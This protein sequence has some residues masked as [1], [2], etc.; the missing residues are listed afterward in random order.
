MKRLPAFVKK[1]ALSIA[2]LSAFGISHAD[3]TISNENFAIGID[4]SSSF[5]NMLSVFD[6]IGG[7]LDTGG[8]HDFWFDG[9]G[10][11]SRT[12]LTIRR[13][14]GT[15]L[16]QRNNGIGWAV[17]P[18]VTHVSS[19]GMDSV[20][21]EGEPVAG[22]FMR[23]VI[24]IDGGT[25]YARITDTFTNNQG[26]VIQPGVLDNINPLSPSG[27]STRNDVQSV[28][29]ANDFASATIAPENTLTVGFGSDDMAYRFSAGGSQFL[30]NPF[31][32]AVI[33]PNGALGDGTLQAGS[34]FGLMLPAEEHSHT[35]FLAFGS[36]KAEATEN[37][38][39]ATGA[40]VFEIGPVGDQFVDEHALMSVAVPIN[41]P[42]GGPVTWTVDGPAG[43]TISSSGT[44][45]WTPG[46]LDGGNTYPVEVEATSGAS[47]ATTSFN[48]TVIETNTPPVIDPIADVSVDEGGTAMSQ[49]TASDS[50]IPVQS[51]TF[52][53]ATGPSGATVH[54]STGAFS[55]PTDEADGPGSY[56]VTVRVRDNGS[57]LLTDET[58]FTVFVEEVNQAPVLDAI[59]DKAVTIG[60]TLSFTATASDAD[61]PAN[62]LTFTLEPGAPEG[63]TIDPM[64][65]AFDWTPGPGTAGSH[66]VAVRV[67]DDGEPTMSDTDQ[68]LI[69]VEPASL[70]VTYD[71]DHS[72]EY[73]DPTTLSV[74]ITDSLNNPITGL[75]M[76]FT[77]GTFAGTDTT[78]SNG[79]ASVSLVLDQPAGSPG[80][81]IDFTGNGTFEPF[82]R[83][84]A[85]EILREKVMVTY[86]GDAAVVTGS[87]VVTRAA[88][89][90]YATAFQEADGYP[91]DFSG[92]AL[93]YGGFLPG[94]TGSVPDV[95]AGPAPIDGSGRS[96]FFMDFPAHAYEF[97]IEVAANDY[98]RV[99]PAVQ[100]NLNI[101]VG[102]PRETNGSG[103]VP[104]GGGNGHGNFNLRIAYILKRAGGRSSFDFTSEDGHRYMVE[105]TEL[106]QGALI[107]GAGSDGWKSAITGLARVVKTHSS[108][109]QQTTFVNVPFTV[110]AWD[111]SRAIPMMPDAYGILL[112]DHNGYIWLETPD[113][114]NLGGGNIQVK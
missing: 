15:L 63:A 73:S 25:K 111:G 100:F 50:D 74:R 58:T 93:L 71:G 54:P 95:S 96:M 88:V 86:L 47:S 43:M 9:F 23:R 3:F 81:T 68:F 79:E 8:P 41:N 103:W 51:L 34:N 64:T 56:P 1:A 21:I 4:N 22:I 35:W 11:F 24:R 90:L 10:G 75:E 48:V 109:G 89:R 26:I 80:V 32:M 65:G 13:Q 77:L 85:Y 57:G 12:T 105:M 30:T 114:L 19:A 59:T 52:S 40:I 18:I 53:L 46:E 101:G 69:T 60:A 14:D 113:V 94:N 42:G 108:T 78:D 44:V 110:D 7:R 72:G 98:W 16:A 106:M 29:G 82:T 104:F 92:Q 84:E 107:L 76:T 39:A 102:V 91:G 66:V 45:M 70:V 31:G 37:Y 20:V 2:A 83:N 27:T 38:V 67:T 55:W 5:G 36:T 6:E 97:E 28:L 62:Q 49:A 33:D 112:L 87:N 99:A 61:L 17:G